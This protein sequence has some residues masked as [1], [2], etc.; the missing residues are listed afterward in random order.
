MSAAGALDPDPVARLLQP[1]RTAVDARRALDTALEAGLALTGTSAGFVALVRPGSDLQVRATAGLIEAIAAGLRSDGGAERASISAEG[2]VFPVRAADTGDGGRV[3]VGMEAPEQELDRAAPVVLLGLARAAWALRDQRRSAEVQRLHATAQRVAAASLD[4]RSVL[5][6]IVRDAVELLAADS[7]DMLLADRERSVLR[8]VAVADFSEEMV[9]FE[10]GLDEGVSARAMAARRTTIVDDYG[11]YRHR[12]RSLDRY[13]FRA[14]LCAPLIARGEAIGAL[15]VHATHPGR[16]FTAEDAALLTTF[17]D[18]AAI[19][20]DNAR[21]YEN[22]A[23]LAKDLRRVN[24]ELERA[25]TL[26]QRVVQQVLADRGPGAVAAEL[27][28]LLRVP[29][30]VQDHLFRVLGG[31]SP[32]GGDDDWM[33]VAVPRAIGTSSELE[34]EL[35][36]AATTR[37]PVAI[38]GL[39]AGRGRVVVPVGTGG[40]ASGYLVLGSATELGSLDRALVEVA[41]TG[42]ALEL[43]KLRTRSEAELRVQGDLVEDLV[44]GR[45]TSAEAIAARAAAAGYDLSEPRLVL[46]L[47]V[48]ADR[49]ED[50][51][52]GI[53]RQ[54]L[55]VL[56]VEL[57]SSSAASIV[58]SHGE[59]VVALLAERTGAEPVKLAEELRSL[60]ERDV[61]GSVSVGVGGSC[62]DP[63]SY[64]RAFASAANAVDAM[65]RLGKR[66]VVVEAERLGVDRIVIEASDRAELEAF[67]RRTLAPLLGEAA[68][69]GDLLPTLRAYV[70]SGFNQRETAR[71]CFLHFNTVAYRLRRI[72]VLLAHDLDDPGTRLDLTFALRIGALLDLF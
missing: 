10:M 68:Q 31:A 40:G 41:A 17:A 59:H 55:D 48:D 65:A 64:T 58:G 20:I 57:A 37:S 4:L 69:R 39:D 11:R 12:V 54:M 26:Q 19:A 47:R 61:G 60:L 27:S 52:K 66:G 53:R 45:F 38:T 24:E 25:L 18:H 72:E 7:G 3:L 67:A 49:P 15:N 43:A 34:R 23:Q 51:A 16:R 9:G 8:V 5:T 44:T 28:H 46:A 70:D 33:A 21:R 36:A 13:G 50:G 14:V 29:V 1:I 63:A 30:V 35:E 42:V 2:T 22:E 71:R 56:R 32:T 6:E 62:S